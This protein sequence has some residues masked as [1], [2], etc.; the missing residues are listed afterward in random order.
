MSSVV[1]TIAVAMI[2]IR[3]TGTVTTGETD[4]AMTVATGAAKT[5]IGDKD[6]VDGGMAAVIGAKRDVIAA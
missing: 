2:V 5:P 3:V 1:R 4:I 6:T